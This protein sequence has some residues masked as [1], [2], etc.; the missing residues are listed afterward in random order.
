LHI[1]SQEQIWLF[2]ERKLRTQGVYLQQTKAYRQYMMQRNMHF[3]FQRAKGLPLQIY[4]KFIKN[5]D[6]TNC[7]V[8]FINLHHG[9]FDKIVDVNNEFV[10]TCFNSRGIADNDYDSLVLD[11]GY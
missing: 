1:S 9:S 5:E 2:K 7:G 8:N 6:I 10:V 4:S 11:L 3:S